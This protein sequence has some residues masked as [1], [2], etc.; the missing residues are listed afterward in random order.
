MLEEHT[1]AHHGSSRLL[2]FGPGVCSIMDLDVIFEW[3]FEGE[4]FGNC[5]DARMIVLARL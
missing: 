1:T 4:S 3:Y 2:I 5:I